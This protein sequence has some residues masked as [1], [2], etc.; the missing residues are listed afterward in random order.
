MLT[1]INPSPK[2]NPYSE[3]NPKYYPDW[4]YK[5][6]LPKLKSAQELFENWDFRNW[7]DIFTSNNSH[8]MIFWQI[9]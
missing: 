8:P 6:V 5:I 3:E 7:H 9:R 2:L 4:I 1:K